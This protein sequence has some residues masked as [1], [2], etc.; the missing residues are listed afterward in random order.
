MSTPGIARRRWTYDTVRG[1]LTAVP[2]AA[3]PA[4]TNRTALW[5]LVCGI[6]S[7]PALAAFGAGGFI[8]LAAVVLGAFGIRRARQGAGRLALAIV[9]VLLGTLSVLVIAGYFISGDATD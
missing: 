1:I 8:G 3:A 5:S 9:G 4:A 6:V 2:D 7:V